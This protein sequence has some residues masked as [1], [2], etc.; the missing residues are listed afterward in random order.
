MMRQ[1]IKAN[2]DSAS[3]HLATAAQPS[4]QSLNDN[5]PELI[6]DE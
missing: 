2:H 6:L 3:T 4:K 1:R 5:N